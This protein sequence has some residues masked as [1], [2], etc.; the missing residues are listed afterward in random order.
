MGEAAGFILKSASYSNSLQFAVVSIKSSL[1]IIILIFFLF[2]SV[3]SRMQA[4][5]ADSSHYSRSTSILYALL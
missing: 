2:S 4:K 5:S 3:F 1:F